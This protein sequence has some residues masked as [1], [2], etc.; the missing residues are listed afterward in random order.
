MRK[1][2]LLG[3][4]LLVLF[5]MMAQT[6]ISG[7]VQSEKGEPLP[8][9]MIQLKGTTLT[10]TTDGKGNFELLLPESNA[11]DITYAKGVSNPILEHPILNITLDGYESMEY[12]VEQ[13]RSIRIALRPYTINQIMPQRST[14]TTAQRIEVYEPTWQWQDYLGNDWASQIVGLRVNPMNEPGNIPQL[15][16]RGLNLLQGNQQPLLI[17]DGVYINNFSLQNLSPEDIR[18]VEFLNSA[19]NYGSLAGNGVIE[20]QTNRGSNLKVGESKIAYHTQFGFSQNTQPYSLNESTNRIILNPNAPQPLLGELNTEHR[21]NTPLPNLQDYQKDVLFQRGSYTNHQ[22]SFSGRSGATNYYAS[23]GHLKDQST[24]KGNDGFT[25]TSLR[26]NLDHQLSKKWSLQASTA[27]TFSNQE[28]LDRSKKSFL[29]QSLFL[30]PIFDLSVSNEEDN[31]L[32]DWDIDNT[33]NGIVNPLYLNK[34]IEQTTKSNR[35]MGSLA[36]NY[37]LNDWLKLRYWG[38][39][40]KGTD[41]S[42]TFIER[43]FLS[44][45]YPTFF[46][47][48]VVNDFQ[49][50]NGGGLQQ[51]TFEFES[52]F[53]QASANFDKRFGGFKINGML[54]W[55]YENAS[56]LTAQIQ[57]EDLIIAG[58]KSLSNLTQNIQIASSEESSVTYSGL[59]HGHVDYKNKY[60]FDGSFRRE[61]SSLF[62]EAS[63]FYHYNVGYRLSEDINVKQL[64]ELKFSVGVSQ[65]GIRPTYAQRF[66]TTSLQAAGIM[67]NSNLQPT[68][69]RELSVGVDATIWRAFDLR[70]THFERTISKQI[71]LAALS[72]SLG[73]PAQWQNAGTVENTGYEAGLN[74]DFAK[75]FHAKASGLVWTL[76]STFLHTNAI[77]T[78]LEAPAFADNPTYRIAEKEKL[79]TIYGNLFAQNASQ[80]H[81]SL[82]PDDY[83][84]NELGYLVHKETVNTVNE[85]PIQVLDKNGDP[86]VGAVGNIN[87]A[88][89]MGFA[90]TIG[91]KQL[92]LFT[93]FDWQQGGNFYNWDKQLLYSQQR[94]QDFERSIAADFFDALYQNGQIN[95]HFVEDASYWRLRELALLFHL[96]QKQLGKL[97]P[98]FEQIQVGVRGRNLWSSN[99]LWGFPSLSIQNTKQEDFD[100]PARRTFVVDVKIVF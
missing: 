91:Y 51:Q 44:T 83:V 65:T 74:I 64:Q 99:K 68:T 38:S 7:L 33:G 50:S 79:G 75:L 80:L 66:G 32:Y 98:L 86:K 49:E 92:K 9:A 1:L 30:T 97:N 39:A 45:T 40:D 11:Y 88:F 20:I 8:N 4:S 17:V 2:I 34:H 87:P 81:E 12:A 57:G 61:Q 46:G 55:N 43:G 13:K 37:Q 84:I 73:V 14:T 26:I 63:N 15:T 16:M 53:A 69:V 10:T 21:F 41:R 89:N 29:A 6:T 72:G 78:E 60:L 95:N 85:L 5:N 22:L 70:F 23:I 59:I 28:L 77:I 52:L 90:H 71:L 25:R 31:S 100:Y 94:H 18:H 54:S 67:A 36:L 93:L 35:L 82:N 76:N 58:E 96:K 24:I 56:N 47:T 3:A 48:A 62:E 19:A 42:T 27:Y